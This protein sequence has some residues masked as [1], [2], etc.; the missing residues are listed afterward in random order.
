MGFL[1]L[2]APAF[3]FVFVLGMAAACFSYG[4]A[5]K[6]LPRFSTSLLATG[7]I[8]SFVLE[9]WLCIHPFRGPLL[10]FLIGLSAAC[11]LA[12]LSRNADGPLWRWISSKWLVWIG[13]FS[14]SLYLLHFP[15]QQLFWQGLVCPFHLSRAAGFLIVAGPGTVVI[16]IL[17]YL[18]Y[19]VFER[20]FMRRKPA[21]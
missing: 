12:I 17:S 19:R 1:R 7:I 9:I 8:F 4:E 5:E 21:M 16:L 14:Y 2:P 15:L 6:W 20:P 18:F 13:G 3:I 11:F 10:D